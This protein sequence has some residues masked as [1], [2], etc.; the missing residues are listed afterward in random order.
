MQSRG[1]ATGIWRKNSLSMKSPAGV[2]PVERHVQKLAIRAARKR[3]ASVNRRP[4]CQLR[5]VPAISQSIE[6]SRG[7]LTSKSHAPVDTISLPVLLAL[8]RGAVQRKQG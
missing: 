7:G 3:R 2:P 1:L 4:D 5:T 6:R 8:T